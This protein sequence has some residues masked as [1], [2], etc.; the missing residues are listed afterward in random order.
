[1]ARL[2][3]HAIGEEIDRVRGQQQAEDDEQDALFLP[4]H[5]ALTFVACG[6]AGGRYCTVRLNVKLPSS[7]R[8]SAPGKG[9]ENSGSACMRLIVAIMPFGPFAANVSTREI[10][11]SPLN[12]G[13]TEIRRTSCGSTDSSSSSSVLHENARSASFAFTKR[14]CA[15]SPARSS[16]C[17]FCSAISLR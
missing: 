10:V 6:I 17:S 3:A 8:F 16:A 13:A 1:Q 7:L 14:V 9:F 4:D 12:P 5:R 2:I 11:P 15:S